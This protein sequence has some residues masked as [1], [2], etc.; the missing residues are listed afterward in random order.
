MA[1][2]NLFHKRFA[3][4]LKGLGSQSLG[5]RKALPVLLFEKST[6]SPFLVGEK[7]IAFPWNILYLFLLFFSA[8]SYQFSPHNYFILLQ[9]TWKIS[10][11]VKTALCCSGTFYR[12]TCKWEYV[13]FQELFQAWVWG[14]KRGAYSHLPV[15]IC[16]SVLPNLTDTKNAFGN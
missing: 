6:F 4:D 12:N 13:G 14:C 1:G 7:K 9:A 2:T 11:P 8:F 16:S 3:G 5:L 10:S 15:S